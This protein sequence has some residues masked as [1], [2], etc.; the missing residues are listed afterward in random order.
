M[1]QKEIES[2]KEAGIKVLDDPMAVNH[3]IAPIREV[4]IMSGLHRSMTEERLAEECVVTAGMLYSD[5]KQDRKYKDLR[6]QEISY[7]FKN[8]FK[9]RLT[10]TVDDFVTYKTLIGWIEAYVNHYDYKCAIEAIYN[11]SIP[12]EKQIPVHQ[13][14]EQEIKTAIWEAFKEYKEYKRQEPETTQVKVSRPIS[15]AEAIKLPIT[16]IDYGGF[17]LK[18]MRENNYAKA[19]ESLANAFER[20]LR[21]GEKWEKL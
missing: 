11:R 6:I 3:L 1:E 8:G 5:I 10:K 18:W 4:Y 16:C 15:I 2:I 12:P 17:R 9:G 14:T 19:D 7:C 13:M 20:I 21:N